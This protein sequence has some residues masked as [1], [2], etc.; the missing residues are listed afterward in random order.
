MLANKTGYNQL[1]FH[2]NIRG[3]LSLI[4]CYFYLF[5]NIVQ[6]IIINIS[7]HNQHIIQI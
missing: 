3:S 5:L 4:R 6:I 2:F 1:I 7:M